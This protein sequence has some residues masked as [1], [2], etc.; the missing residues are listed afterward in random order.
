MDS[1]KHWNEQIGSTLK[2]LLPSKVYV[3]REPGF[4][5][6]SMTK[7]VEVQSENICVVCIDADEFEF[8]MLDAIFLPTPRDEYLRDLI[9]DI[10]LD[11][12]DGVESLFEVIKE[13]LGEHSERVKREDYDS[14]KKSYS[15]DLNKMFTKS[16]VDIDV[17]DIKIEVV[18][19][20]GVENVV[21]V[22]F[23]DGV[24]STTALIE[25]VE[26]DDIDETI[27]GDDDIEEDLEDEISDDE[28]Y[29]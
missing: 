18:C 25:H 1:I 7:V 5:A 14:W 3:D 9:S 20:K 24:S 28:D 10:V 21:F 27:D 29:E 6:V 4:V 26:E 13:T 8:E 17:S 22:I 23:A 15:K 19:I 2:E 12:S 11:T 16:L